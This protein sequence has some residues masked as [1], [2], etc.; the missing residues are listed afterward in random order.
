MAAETPLANQKKAVAPEVPLASQPKVAPAAPTQSP[1]FLSNGASNNNR[2]NSL[3]TNGITNPSLNANPNPPIQSNQVKTSQPAAG[4]NQPVNPQTQTV[5]AN[6]FAQ[7]TDQNK[8]GGSVVQPAPVQIDINSNSPQNPTNQPSALPTQPPQRGDFSNDFTGNQQFQ[9]AQTDF[10]NSQNNPQNPPANPLAPAVAP[11]TLPHPVTGNSSPFPQT[12]S[13]PNNPSEQTLDWN[14][15]AN[16]NYSDF[17]DN[18]TSA[19]DSII[20]DLT[21]QASTQIGNSK[22]QTEAMLAQLTQ[23]QQLYTMERDASVSQTD[24]NAANLQTAAEMGKEADQKA[25]DLQADVSKARYD[26]QIAVATDNNSRYL[27]FLQGKF[28]AAGMSD[29]S[30]GLQLIGK[31]MTTSQLSLNQLQTDAGAAQQTF[32]NNNQQI[33]NS[34]FKQASDIENTRITSDNQTTFTMADKIQAIQQN[35]LTSVANQNNMILSTIKELSS[36]KLAVAQDVTKDVMSAAQQHLDQMKFNHQVT[37][38]AASQNIQQKQADLAVATLDWSKQY[39]AGELGISQQNANIAAGNL[40]ISEYNANPAGLPNALGVGMDG[41]GGLGSISEKYEGSGAGT[42]SSGKG[43]AGGV[44]Y[45]SYQL[46]G[47]NIQGFLDKSGY[48]NQFDGLKPGTAEFNAKWKEAA[49]NPAFAKA[50]NDYI[51]STHYQPLVNK[52]SSQG[53]DLSGKGKAVQEMLFSTGTQYGPNTDVVSRALAGKDVANMSDSDI[54]SA[55]QDYKAKTVQ[56]YFGSS[57]P[58]VRSGVAN[59]IQ[60]EKN[61]LVG[62]AGQSN[63]STP[64]SSLPGFAAAESFGKNGGEKAPL[65]PQDQAWAKMGP[66]YQPYSAQQRDLIASKGDIAI[67]SGDDSYKSGLGG[68]GDIALQKYIL[69][70]TDGKGVISSDVRTKANAIANTF[71][72]SKDATDFQA[73]KE[74]RDAIK[75]IGNANGTMSPTD[76]QTLSFGFANSLNPGSGVKVGAQ[77]DIR[78]AIQSSWSQA[79]V[80]LSKTFNSTGVFTPADIKSMKSTIDKRYN[81][82]AQTYQDARANYIPQI[83]NI[84][85]RLDDKFIGNAM[86]DAALSALAKEKGFNLEKARANPD[87]SDDEIQKYLETLK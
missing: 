42:I 27:G 6:N 7:S 67:A 19:Y 70:K 43:D 50:Q 8:Q 46:S 25:N 38:D 29:S 40:R 57:S 48:A 84:D 79:G 51:A 55:V 37:Y 34:Y 15:L 28:A 23:Q 64:S 76:Q 72:A 22:S 32:L 44:S 85:S 45:G 62:L 18:R 39:Q 24:A 2:G 20:G 41:S 1:S 5:A 69:A 11:S 14:Q 77:E 17:L 87:S 30:A 63:Q 4:G 58:A 60:N 33:L 66:Q 59:R 54:V 31:Y 3:L 74:A 16:G 81:S 26:T 86:P 21:A 80:N 9:K 56:Q 53:I 61:D 35:K 73:V 83:K 65:S 49:Q 71:N 78:A 75:N 68:A 10:V 36:T 52:L 13:D 12:T 82:A 47:G